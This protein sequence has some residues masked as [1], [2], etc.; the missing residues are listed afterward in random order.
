MSSRHCTLDA[1]GNAIAVIEVVV[2]HAPEENTLKYYHDNG[3]VLVQYNVKETDLLDITEKL[4][5]PDDVSL[6]LNS[7]CN[8]YNANA[9]MRFPKTHKHK[10]K[11]CLQEYDVYSIIVVTPIGGAV[12]DY[13]LTQDELLAQGAKDPKQVK[14]RNSDMM[15][16]RSKCGCMP[17]RV[18]HRRTD[19][20]RAAI[21]K[22]ERTLDRSYSG[23]SSRSYRRNS[24]KGSSY[25]KRW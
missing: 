24:R 13:C 5:H 19:A 8:N 11:R 9:I 2:T 22:M 17:T 21:A 7:K 25:K 14:V 16:W 15:V 23:Y 4:K 1:D 10:C 3:I 12:Y 20:E 18:I 6:C